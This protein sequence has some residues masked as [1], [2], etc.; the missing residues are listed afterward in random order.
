MKFRQMVFGGPAAEDSKV[1]PKP[2]VFGVF[3]ILQFSQTKNFANEHI[4]EFFREIPTVERFV[5]FF[6]HENF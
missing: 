3:T 4:C 6:V 5:N 1:L 2:D